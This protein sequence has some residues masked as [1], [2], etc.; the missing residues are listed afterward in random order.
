MLYHVLGSSPLNSKSAVHLRY[1]PIRFPHQSRTPYAHARSCRRWSSRASAFKLWA[2][3]RA[4]ERSTARAVWLGD[5]AARRRYIPDWEQR[6][7]LARIAELHERDGL[8][9]HAIGR[10]LEADRCR[11]EGA[12]PK[13]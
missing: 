12:L 10:L 4:S 9:F 6:A 8:G 1:L 7:V 2:D 5:A 3:S 11:A 13:R